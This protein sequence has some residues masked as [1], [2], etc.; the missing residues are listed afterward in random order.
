MAAINKNFV[1]KKGLEVNSNL[2]VANSDTNR[3]GIGTTV[4]LYQLHLSSGIGATYATI[5]GYTTT[6][7][8]N[9]INDFTINGV[10]ASFGQVVGYDTT[11]L[12]WITFAEIG[13][14]RN[15]SNEVAT[16]GQTIFNVV[17]EVG[18]LDVFVNG[19]K[20]S[21]NDF[22]ATDGTTIILN[23]PCF[24][25]EQV[26]LISYA[27]VP[28]GIGVT[29]IPGINVKRN[30]TLVGTPLTISNVNFVGAAVTTDGTG[31]G[32]TV[33]IGYGPGDGGVV[34]QSTSKSTAVTLNSDSGEITLNSAA[35]AANTTVT[36]TIN[37][38]RITETDLLILN[39][40][41][42]GT[43][44]AYSLD[45]RC[46]NGSAIISVRNLTAGS[47]SE[48]IVIR[49]AIFRGSLV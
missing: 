24:G 49:F 7:N 30:G 9:I 12:A 35:L 22:E 39:H 46:S 5:S 32:V 45:S 31:V 38:N 1:V 23:T 17:Y 2:I 41:K 29:G 20:L 27:N 42:I 43:F 28:T 19:A 33:T 21:P 36:F 44:G 40:A 37:N 26:E 15:S 8:L 10:A 3:I 34:T 25:G 18:L 4:P 14:V 11:G 6:S 47:L 16:I 13:G 48:A